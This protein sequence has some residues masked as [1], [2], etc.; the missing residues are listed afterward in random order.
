MTAKVAMPV[1]DSDLV[2]PLAHEATAMRTTDTAGTSPAASGAVSVL[3][4]RRGDVNSTNG[5]TATPIT[6]TP[7]TSTT[8]TRTTTTRTTSSWCGSSADEIA[9]HAELSFEDVLLAHLDC[10]QHKRNSAACL[11]FEAHLA[12]NLWTLYEAFASRTYKPGRSTCFIIKWP[13]V[14]EVWAAPYADRVGHH[15]LHL[16]VGPR[17]TAGFIADSCACI[18]GR[19]TLYAAERLEAK[20][21]SLTQNWQRP[22]YYLKCDIRNFFVSIR[23]STVHEQLARKIREPFLLWLAETILFHDPRTDVQVNATPAELALV[24]PAK[25]LFSQDSDH[26]LPIGNLSSQFFANVH[27]DDVDQYVKH[28][29]RAPHYIRYV[30]D[31]VLLHESAQ[32]LNAW[33]DDIDAFLRTRLGLALHPKKTVLQ[34]IARGID[35]AGQVISPYRRRIRTRTANEALRR[36]STMPEEDLFESANSYF[37]LHRQATRSH[38]DRAR[39]AKLLRQRGF[40]VDRAFTKTYRRET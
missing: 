33:R 24:P 1:R 17:F 26:G 20:V 30:D 21:R 14:R 12:D 40:S 4:N 19:G 31:I 38:H 8:A 5:T 27:L 23:K 11:E 15:L 36:L 13:K 39:I 25:S 28:D 3:S 9:S 18:P 29:L 32:Q 10:R 2:V 37:G 7:R 35:F 6:P 16:K 34:P 22:G